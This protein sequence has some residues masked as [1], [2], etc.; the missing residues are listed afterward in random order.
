MDSKLKFYQPHPFMGYA[1]NP[2]HKN[3]NE[4][5]FRGRLV[6]P[7]DIVCIGGSTTY[8]TGVLEEDSYCYQLGE[9]TKRNVL[10]AG[11]PGGTT[12]HFISML[13]MKILPLNPKIIIFHIGFNDLKTRLFHPSLEPDYS[14]AYRAWQEPFY[15]RSWLLSKLID[16][17]QHISKVIEYDKQGDLFNNW[18][19]SNADIFRENVKTLVAICHSRNIRVI[20]V[21]EPTFVYGQLEK[22]EAD[23]WFSGMKQMDES[24]SSLSKEMMVEYVDLSEM[25]NVGKYFADWVHVNKEGNRIKAKRLAEHLR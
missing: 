2:Q 18:I 22:K 24:L 20:L 1:L 3:H 8:D 9:I 10:N 15:Y 16:G 14:N 7:V 5:G 11:L 25:T 17:N 12:A 13:A 6:L 21:N 4:M 23:I 19:Y